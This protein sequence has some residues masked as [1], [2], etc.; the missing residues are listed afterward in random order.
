MRTRDDLIVAGEKISPI[1]V[2]EDLNGDRRMGQRVWRLA[3]PEPKTPKRV[4]GTHV[5]VLGRWKSVGEGE[6]KGDRGLGC[7]GEGKLW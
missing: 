1:E 4:R 7:S 2:Q 3:C 5:W 6:R